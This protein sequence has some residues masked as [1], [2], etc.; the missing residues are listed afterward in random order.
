MAQ[1]VFISFLGSTLYGNCK[2]AYP[3]EHF[4]SSETRFVQQA[5]LE[6]INH[7]DNSFPDKI[8]L[9]LTDG[10]KG[11]RLN[12]WD[13]NTIERFNPKTKKMEPHEGLEVVL[14]RM[15]LINRVNCIAIPDGKDEKEIWDIFDIIFNQL[16]QLKEDD[17]FLY[18]DLTHGFR[19]LPMLLLVLGDYAKLFQ[20]VKIAH[21]SYGNF[22]VRDES[23]TAPFVDLLPLS[24]LQDWK[25]AANDFISFGNAERLKRITSDNI[26]PV[27]IKTEGSELEKKSKIAAEKLR[28]L[29]NNIYELS[30]DIKTN[31]GKKIIKGNES[32]EIKRILKYLKQDLIKPLNPILEKLSESVGKFKEDDLNNMFAAVEWCIDKQLVQ[33][34]ITI[35]QEGIVSF[36]LENSYHNKDQREYTSGFL[37][38]YG[39]RFD[40]SKFSLKYEDRIDLKEKLSGTQNIGRL[41]DIY[42]KIAS[43]RSDIN[44]AGIGGEPRKASDFEKQLIVLYEETKMNVQQN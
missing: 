32:A 27:L 6:W 25:V 33:E 44:H 12:N 9:L 1:K 28:D 17:L 13:K 36:L 20:N 24:K 29:N 39:K 8:F 38:R 40:E 10:A 5:T 41:S 11:S 35:L 2:Y 43:L 18:L 42:S 14:E 7:K 4:T 22:E 26:R 16:R 30:L 15:N 34:G 21:I 19:Y 31:R 23:D 3:T 37:S